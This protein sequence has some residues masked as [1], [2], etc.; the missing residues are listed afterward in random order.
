MAL[1][2]FMTFLIVF[3]SGWIGVYF[4]TGFRL[5]G[6]SG[7]HQPY[8]TL[9][10]MALTI[11]TLIGPLTLFAGRMTPKPSWYPDAAIIAFWAM[12]IMLLILPM[13]LAKDLGLFFGGIT[14]KISSLLGAGPGPTFD[15]DRRQFLMNVINL[16][17]LGSTGLLSGIGYAVARKQPKVVCLDIHIGGLPAAFDGLKIAQITDLH[18]GASL[19]RRKQLQAIVEAI[20]AEKPDIIVF[21]G[22]LAD[23]Y[24]QDLREDTAPLAELRALDGKYFI[25]GN[26]EYFWDL[27]GWMS[28]VRNLGFTILMNE[29]RVLWRG[30]S[31]LVIAGVPDFTAEYMMPKVISDPEAAARDG[32]PDARKILLA[33]RPGSCYAAERAGF[34]LQISGHT[35]G[36][37]FWPWTWLIH[38]VQPFSAGLYR[39]RKTRLYVSRGTGTW[40]PPTRLGNPSEIPLLTL[41]C[42]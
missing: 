28:E 42:G 33:H 31:C 39:F 38:I 7:L 29:H 16:A 18:I 23:G 11:T 37:Q 41:R 34:D 22:D 32:P 15:P 30:E 27:A 13:L 40:G 4:Y 1:G 35:H 14:M 20:N 12:G 3:M 5:I 25:T 2:R 36:G 10:W 6:P 9:A 8:R 24:V 19:I 17:L 21:T 26:H